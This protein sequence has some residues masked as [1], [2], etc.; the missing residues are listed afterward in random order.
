MACSAM[1]V[2]RSMQLCQ[3]FRL[4]HGWPGQGQDATFP[5]TQHM[6]TNTVINPRSYATILL[7][8]IQ[9]C[10]NIQMNVEYERVLIT[11]LV[12]RCWISGNVAFW[13]WKLA[14]AI[15]A[16]AEKNN[17]KRNAGEQKP[18]FLRQ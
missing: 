12:I 9:L 7:F 18:S 6:I 16:E 14:Q 11:V 3:F 15:R 5:E 4:Q 17:S 10:Y 2:Q 1:F 13:P 8:N